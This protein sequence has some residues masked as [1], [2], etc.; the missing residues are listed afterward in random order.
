MREDR[1][2]NQYALKDALDCQL[3]EKRRRQ[4]EQYEAELVHI[5]GP[6][7]RH[8]LTDAFGQ[9]RKNYHLRHGSGDEDENQEQRKQ[10]TS[11]YLQE[12]QRRQLRER[13]EMPEMRAQRA[14][15]AWLA[16][17][18]DHKRRLA[19]GAADS[20]R[21]DAELTTAHSP[22]ERLHY[23]P[24]VLQ[25]SDQILPMEQR[26]RDSRREYRDAL[27]RQREASAAGL[28][29]SVSLHF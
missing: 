4:L 9:P 8:I 14:R 28:N 12:V 23:R 25:F 10:Q 29:K 6:T 3:A 20:L 5:Y 7:M 2:L 21:G 24:S 1:R 27:D 17:W 15:Q 16:A 26:R 19:D 22:S 11:L 13:E 18:E